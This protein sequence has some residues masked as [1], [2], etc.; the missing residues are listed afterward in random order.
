MDEA[1]PFGFRE[2]LAKGIRPVLRRFLE[3]L[4]NW[5]GDRQG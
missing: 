4:L 5:E 2:D 1:P 3:T